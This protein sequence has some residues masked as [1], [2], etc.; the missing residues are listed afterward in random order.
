MKFLLDNAGHLNDEDDVSIFVVVLFIIF[1]AQFVHFQSGWTPLMIASSA[2][3]IEIVRY[4]LECGADV[5]AQNSTKQT[6]LHYA[7]SKG[8][9]NV[10]FVFF[11]FFLTKTTF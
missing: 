3:R 7:A 9:L 5:T 4:L 8:H 2:G 6:A 10:I 1:D 11:C